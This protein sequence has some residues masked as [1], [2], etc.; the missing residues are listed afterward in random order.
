ML[1]K[2]LSVLLSPEIPV[3]TGQESDTVAFPLSQVPASLRLSASGLTA[4]YVPGKGGPATYRPA[5]STAGLKA[6]ATRAK[7]SA[8]SVDSE[9]GT[10]AEGTREPCEVLVTIVLIKGFCEAYVLETRMSCVS[11]FGR[12]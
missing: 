7:P 11:P 12:D 9:L 10:T 5:P 1:C 2:G 8:A 6:P 4:T 3:A